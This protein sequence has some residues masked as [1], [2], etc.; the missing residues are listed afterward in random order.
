LTAGA[1]AGAEARAR[2]SARWGKSAVLF[3]SALLFNLTCGLA[4]F[5][6]IFYARDVFHASAGQIGWL[7]AM[8]QLAYLAGCLAFPPLFGLLLPRHYLLAATGGMALLL[9]G[10]MS[11]RSLAGL[12]VLY[13]LSGFLIALFWPPMMGWLSRGLEE[14]TLGKTLRN[15]NLTWSSSHIISPY[16]AG[17]LL[18]R[19]HRL[20]IWTAAGL[21]ALACLYLLASCQALPN[22]RN[23]RERE[24]TGRQN[25][26]TPD[27]STPLRY[28][29]WV[30]MVASYLL[31]GI[32]SSIFPLFLRDTLGLPESR[33]GLLLLVQAA[34][35]T[36]CF[37]LLG[38]SSF[39]HFRPLPMI[40][41][42]AGL[43]V[44]AV[45]LAFARSFLPLALILA[46]T[47]ALTALAYSES[48][49][50]GVSGSARRAARMAINEATRTAGFVAGASGGGLLLQQSSFRRTL[51]VTAAA[52]LAATA[53]QALLA[54]RAQGRKRG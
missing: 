39:W 34:F 53:A 6:I 52:I 11:S 26:R 27:R 15:F 41:G 22:V 4:S 40:L 47:G 25:S 19:G 29:G 8:P 3:P 44:L 36:A 24:P 1:P 35:S 20:P 38:R 37:W 43:T 54:R 42:Q 21:G 31:M 12:F 48:L 50:H 33:V 2:P 28:P 7:A 10:L 45:G 5:G 46:P 51:L 14:Q 30:G 13:G 23:D 17:L 9:T 16:A 18:E 32:L 49:F